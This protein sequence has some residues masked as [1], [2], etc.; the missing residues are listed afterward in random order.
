[1]SK[2]LTEAFAV[3]VYLDL[4]AQ[5]ESLQHTNIGLELRHQTRQPFYAVF[6]NT[7]SQTTLR[8]KKPQNPPT[9]TTLK[10]ERLLFFE[11]ADHFYIINQ[12]L[13]SFMGQT[14]KYP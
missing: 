6:I 1:M 11:Y 8:K 10:K 2:V 5:E 3:C 7:T 14:V 13:S 9:F 4:G 12:L